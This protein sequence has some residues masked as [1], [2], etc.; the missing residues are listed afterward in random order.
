MPKAIALDAL[1]GAFEDPGSV[2]STPKEAEPAKPAKPADQAVSF[3]ETMEFKGP[4]LFDIET[5]PLPDGDLRRFFQF[6]R[7]K[8]KGRELLDA[9]FDPSTVKYGNTKDPTKRAEKLEAAQEAFLSAKTAACRAMDSAE[10]EQ[11][12]AFRDRAALDARTCQVLTVAYMDA[13]TG[14][15]VLDDG[16]GDERQLLTSFWE[17]VAYCRTK[18]IRIVGFNSNSFDIPVLAR[19]AMLHRIPLPTF[20]N[21][22][23]LDRIFVDLRDAWGC[24]EWQPKGDLDSL[25]TFFG[26]PPKNGEG[27]DFHRLWNGSDEEHNH[28]VEYA[29]NDLDMTLAVAIGLQVTAS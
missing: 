27:A 23:Y 11:F 1:D 28:A 18:N 2:G 5:G 3:L 15:K 20:R 22:R 21:G 24:G 9:E 19:R 14:Q 12:D 17:L 29:L 6:D 10:K 16:D 25:S 4:L 26:G 7:Q 13:A 8:V